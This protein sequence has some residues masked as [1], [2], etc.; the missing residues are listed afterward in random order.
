[1]SD[2][3]VLNADGM[4]LSIV[5]LS[6]AG[7]QEIVK[8]IFMDR[9]SVLANYEDWFVHSP[10]LTIQVPSV[11]MI[12]EYVKVDRT[13]RFSRSNVLLRDGYTCQYCDADYSNNQSELT[14]DHVVPRFHG[15]RT[16]WDNVVAACPSCNLEKSH[17]DHMKPR[18]GPKRPSYYELV[19]KRMSYPIDVPDIQWGEFLGWDPSLVTVKGKNSRTLADG[20]SIW[21]E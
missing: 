16:K 13:V 17:Y 19:N 11:V 4:P 2:T 1:M 8:L 21:S 14:L 15:G 12:N 10:S 7:W 6:T 9:V 5:P 3:L 18:I 20:R